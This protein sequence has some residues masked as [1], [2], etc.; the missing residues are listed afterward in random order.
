[1]SAQRR[2]TLDELWEEFRQE[3]DKYRESTEER[4]LRFEALKKK[5]EESATTIDRQAKKLQK[6]QVKLR[7]INC[8]L[9]AC[10]CCVAQTTIG[11][12]KQ[13][14]ASNV[15]ESDEKTSAIK[16]VSKELLHC[17]CIYGGMCFSG[18]CRIARQSLLTFMNSN[19]S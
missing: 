3:T 16:E 18:F 5:D 2:A 10:S 17:E 7:G 19:R 6:L 14:M 9:D 15:R 1:M 8:C 13:R 4:K 11:Q 12:I